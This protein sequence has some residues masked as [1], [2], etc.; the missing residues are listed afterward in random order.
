MVVLLSMF[1][2][3]QDGYASPAEVGEEVTMVTHNLVHVLRAGRS[4]IF[5]GWALLY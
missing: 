1:C 5:S 2:V 4:S 3:L